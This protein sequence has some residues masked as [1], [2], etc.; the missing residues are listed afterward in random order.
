[1]PA[2]SS[3]GHARQVEVLGHAQDEVFVHDDA[4]RVA[5]VGDPARVLVRAIEGVDLLGA[6]V[7][8]PALAV[9]AAQVRVDQASD[10]HQVADL[11]LAHL[12]PDLGNPPDDLV[13]GHDRILRR[14]ELLP[15]V[16]H[17]VQIAVA[18]PAE[19]DVDADIPLRWLASLNRV[20]R[21]GRGGAGRGVG[22]GIEHVGLLGSASKCCPNP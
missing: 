13:P 18:D 14:H 22:S 6:V 3:G 11:V 4:V 15:L 20:R 16:P 8:V 17:R 9:R 2:Q 7:L 10:G 21:K 1:M 19:E 12:G 5:A